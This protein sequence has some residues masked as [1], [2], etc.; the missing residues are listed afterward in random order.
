MASQYAMNADD[1][2]KVVDLV[3]DTCLRKPEY[4][5]ER[6]CLSVDQ[7]GDMASAEKDFERA[8][9]LATELKLDAQ[10]ESTKVWQARLYLYN[11]KK[12]EAE[13]IAATVD[14]SKLSDTERKAFAP[15]EK[16]A[17]PSPK[18]TPD[19]PAAVEKP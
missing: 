17:Q 12:A 3:P 1:L 13:K 4:L 10:L 19:Q 11:N 9:A 14:M 18:A 8:R 15:L 16:F 2:T 6:A 5:T 7:K